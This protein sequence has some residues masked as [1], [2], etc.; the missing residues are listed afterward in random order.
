MSRSGGR[1]PQ[2][3]RCKRPDERLPRYGG[4][5]MSAVVGCGLLAVAVLSSSGSGTYHSLDKISQ[6][7]EE[8]QEKNPRKFPG[9]HGDTVIG[10]VHELFATGD[11]SGVVVPTGAADAVIPT[12]IPSTFSYRMN[13]RANKRTYGENQR[14]AF[15][16]R[17]HYVGKQEA[18][19]SRWLIWPEA[20]GGCIWMRR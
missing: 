10:S 5:W 12:E 6:S 9:D 14:R 18:F 16:V 13:R 19:K 20:A 15:E 11:D 2:T 8:Q 1:I 4:G 3:V 17:S 7:K